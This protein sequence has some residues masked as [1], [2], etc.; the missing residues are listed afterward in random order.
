MLSCGLEVH[1]FSCENGHFYCVI[2]ERYVLC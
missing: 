2:S 1:L